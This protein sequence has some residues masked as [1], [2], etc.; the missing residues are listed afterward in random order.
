MSSCLHV[1]VSGAMLLLRKAC[2]SGRLT[3]YLCTGPCLTANTSH[4]RDKVSPLE[5]TTISVSNQAKTE[6]EREPRAKEATGRGEKGE[7]KTPRRRPRA[8]QQQSLEGNHCRCN[9]V[10][11]Y[12]PPRRVKIVQL[13]GPG[14][15]DSDLFKIPLF[16]TA[17]KDLQTQLF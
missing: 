3:Q 6:G 1:F 2:K 11:V 17:R 8:K 12:P 13:M 14:F 4:R 16:E 9:S 7:D 15:K 5:S 10:S